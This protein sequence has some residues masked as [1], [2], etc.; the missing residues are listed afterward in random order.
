MSED[1]DLQLRG[2]SCADGGRY[3]PNFARTAPLSGF[4]FRRNNHE[5]QSQPAQDPNWVSPK[6]YEVIPKDPLY[7]KRVRLLGIIE[8][9]LRP[10]STATGAESTA[11]WLGLK[12]LGG[13]RGLDELTSGNWRPVRTRFDV[14]WPLGHGEVGSEWYEMLYSHLYVRVGKFVKEYFGYGNLPAVWEGVAKNY[15]WLDGGFSKQFMGFLEQ[16]AIQDNNMGGWDDLLVKRLHR[17]F[18]VTGVIGKVLETC[19]FDD[20]LFGADTAQKRM[21]KAQ[22]ECTL[23]LEGHQRTKLRAECIRTVLGD[24]PLTP[25]FWPCVDQHT[26]Q[27]M[28]LL[29]PMVNLMDKHFS[30]SEAKSLRNMYQDLHT[31]V[32][33]AGYLSIG[34][35]RSR[36]IFRLSSPFLGEAWDN[37]QQHVDDAIYNASRFASDVADAA[38]ERV[39]RAEHDRRQKGHAQSETILSAALNGLKA[40]QARVMGRTKDAEASDHWY[41]PSRLAKV[42]IVLWPLFQRF[43]TVGPIDP[44]T[45]YADGEN[46]TTLL[47]AQVVYYS[48][49][50]D[51]LEEQGKHYPPLAI[52]LQQNRKERVWNLVKPLCWV[53]YA[54]GAL[55][56]LSFLGQY[57]SIASAVL[58]V[59]LLV[60]EVLITA[61]T[62]LIGIA[63]G[64]MFAASVIRHTLSTVSSFTWELLSSD[65]GFLEAWN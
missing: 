27:V 58:Q 47:K 56:L 61:I 30:D 6:G 29:L 23:E 5:P 18:M 59:F 39:W 50:T 64:I 28:A 42:Q 31:I 3:N 15:P 1:T 10:A 17:E 22:D 57:S 41:P 60:L 38:A 48:G 7:N 9:L 25:D 8:S 12:D 40:V 2:G 19:V 65:I 26:L 43:A 37:D 35:R 36:D 46:V 52:W 62:I 24:D 20:L 63:K 49:R 13:G 21:L 11:A 33:E 4:R 45:R 16:V 14:H 55:L 53:V 34:I 54:A 44:E 51:E 32:A